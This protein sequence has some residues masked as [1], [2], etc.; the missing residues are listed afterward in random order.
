MC[1]FSAGERP[2]HVPTGWG[3]PGSR[4]GVRLHRARDQVVTLGATVGKQWVPGQAVV[5]SFGATHSP[6]I[7][8]PRWRVI[9]PDRRRTVVRRDR[10]SS[11]W[12]RDR[13]ARCHAVQPLPGLEGGPDGA[14]PG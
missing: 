7:R 11:R 13:R 1:P 5:T 9:T 12:S 4:W 3:G 10:W 14:G 8:S 6:L 2:V